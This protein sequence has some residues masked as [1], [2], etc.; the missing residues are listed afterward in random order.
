MNCNVFKSKLEDYMNGMLSYDMEEAMKNHIEKCNACRKIYEDEKKTDEL[1]KAGFSTEQLKFNSSRNDILENIDVNKYN[2]GLWNKA[3]IKVKKGFNKINSHMC[4]NAMRYAGIAAVV[5]L[6]VLCA[7]NGIL[8]EMKNGTSGNKTGSVAMKASEGKSEPKASESK[9]ELSDKKSQVQ[10]QESKPSQKTNEAVLDFQ[11]ARM[12]AD[13]NYKIDFNTPWKTSSDGKISACVDGKGESSQEEGIADIAVREN[14]K[15]NMFLLK[16]N[17]SNNKQLTPMKVEWIDNNTLA[18][19][20]G[21]GYG[22]IAQGGNLYYMNV[23]TMKVT[24]I[25]VSPDGQRTQVKD[26]NRRNDI[27][28]LK[29]LKYDD[30]NFMNSHEDVWNL[31]LNK[32]GETASF[33]IKDSKGNVIPTK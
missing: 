3:Q 29:I 9:P 30:E 33:E 7:K 22:T 28:E 12:N 31:T 18:V 10:E 26:V 32:G 8:T 6:V 4:K 16:I 21:C 11:F 25:Y 20:V 27:L 13:K 15:N 5:L 17:S 23:N 19:I 24:R 1:I 14:D 2:G